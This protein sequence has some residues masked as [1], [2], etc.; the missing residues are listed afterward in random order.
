M[1]IKDSFRYLGD[2][3]SSK[4]D[5]TSM[6]EERIKRSVGSIIELFSL[7]KEV[8]FGDSQINK[9][10][11]L[12][13][14][15]FL[16]RLIYNCEA[17]S[18]ISENDYK[19]LQNAQLSFLRRVMEVPKSTPVAAT[20]LEFAILPIRYEIEKRQLLFLKRILSRE[21]CDPLLVTYE[22]MLKLSSEPNWVNGV[23]DL[24]QKYNLP[25][26]TNI[27]NMSSQTWKSLVVGTI[28][29]QA[30]SQLSHECSTNA[31]TRHLAY[32]RLQKS[33]YI[34]LIGP[35]IVRVLFRTKLRMFGLKTNFKRKYT[36]HS[37]PFCR[38]EQKPLIICSSVLMG[39]TVQSL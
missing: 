4:G 11:L 17:W 6:I 13:Q 9:M 24:R 31:K 10:L 39:F 7:R 5:N 19:Q 21:T 27:Q 30:F 36:S 1:E 15:I 32:G 29:K 20:F 26:N 25:L 14:S 37:F 38:A 16:P 23:L 8:Q 18:N 2:I 34:S 3:F 33:P 35:H 12:Y 22:Q 28:K